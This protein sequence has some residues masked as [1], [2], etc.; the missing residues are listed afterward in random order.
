MNKFILIS[1]IILTTTK[2][3]LAQQAE[4][5][6]PSYIF[7]GVFLPPDSVAQSLRLIHKSYMLNM[8]T[9]MQSAKDENPALRR[10]KLLKIRTD[11]DSSILQLL[12]KENCEAYYEQIDRS[13]VKEEALNTKNQK[14]YDS[15]KQKLK[16]NNQQAQELEKLFLEYQA[17]KRQV[18][19]TSMQNTELG[20]EKILELKRTYLNKVKALIPSDKFEAFKNL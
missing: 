10:Q 3:S 8:Q 2:V 17:Q 14:K 19:L 5:A 13:K 20:K 12:G 18:A 7:E 16:L 11:R 9:Q 15:F 1:F 4:K 6:K